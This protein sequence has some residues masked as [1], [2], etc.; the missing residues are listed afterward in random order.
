M[1]KV[2]ALG[3][4]AECRPDV[5]NTDDAAE[6]VST[7]TPTPSPVVSAKA[8]ITVGERPERYGRW[9]ALPVL[10]SLQPGL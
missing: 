2:F 9:E 5:G 6:G 7:L 3:L 8:Q 10:G 1:E 4:L